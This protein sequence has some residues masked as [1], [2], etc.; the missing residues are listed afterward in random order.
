MVS[1]IPERDFAQMKSA[2]VK[3]TGSQALWKLDPF[4]HSHYRSSISAWLQFKL[5]ATAFN[6]PTLQS[7]DSFALTITYLT[8]TLILETRKMWLKSVQHHHLVHL[9]YLHTSRFGE[10]LVSKLFEF[11]F[12]IWI[13]SCTHH[14][15]FRIV[16]EY[17]PPF[18]NICLHVLGR[19]LP[20]NDKPKWNKVFIP[21]QKLFNSKIKT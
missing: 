5:V 19:T 1:W 17:L 13:V 21:W 11:N 15:T 3:F 16:R 7:G 2:W 20:I 10:I 6:F 8:A 14:P 18:P 12:S 4:F 9:F